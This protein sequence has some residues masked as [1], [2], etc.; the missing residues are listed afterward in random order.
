MMLKVNYFHYSK[1]QN[2][3]NREQRLVLSGQT[4]VW[5]KIKSGVRKGSVLGPLFLIYINDLPDGINSMCKIG[6]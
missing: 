2:L 5:R 1:T 3:E 6:F 4:S